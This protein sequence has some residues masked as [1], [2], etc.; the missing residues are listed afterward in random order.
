MLFFSLARFYI[1]NIIG[2]Y[3]TTTAMTLNFKIH[4][5]RGIATVTLQFALLCFVP[6]N[7]Y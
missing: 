6:T 7:Q 3:S 5:C 2:C 1:V 4:S